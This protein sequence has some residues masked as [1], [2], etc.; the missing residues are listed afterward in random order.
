MQFLQEILLGEDISRVYS[1]KHVGRVAGEE[2]LGRVV[3][4]EDA[5]EDIDID[6]DRRR[7]W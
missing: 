5:D 7:C 3:G 6:T 2:D 4:E 1:K